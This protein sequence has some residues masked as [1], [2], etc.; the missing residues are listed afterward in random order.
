MVTVP[1]RLTVSRMITL[2]IYSSI[3][4]PRRTTTLGALTFNGKMVENFS[5]YTTRVYRRI[6]IRQFMYTY[7]DLHT[8]HLLI[9]RHEYPDDYIPTFPSSKNFMQC[10][11]FFKKQILMLGSFIEELQQI[12]IISFRDINY[13]IYPSEI[14]YR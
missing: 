5:T 10:T 2:S 3:V 11:I 12:I 14:M 13:T 7:F 6:I 8:N 9:H 4:N 1:V